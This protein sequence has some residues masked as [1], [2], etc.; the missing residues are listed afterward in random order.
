MD[1]GFRHQRKGARAKL[2]LRPSRVSIAMELPQFDRLIIIYCVLIIMLG[3]ILIRED[4]RRIW[5]LT[6]FATTLISVLGSLELLIWVFESTTLAKFR[7]TI[8][9]AALLE[10]LK[11]YLFVDLIYTAAYHP[12]QLGLIDGWIHR[13]VYI[14]IAHKLQQTYQ[15]GCVRPFWVMAI[16]T[17]IQAWAA[18]GTIPLD[19][20]NRWFGA[21]FAAFRIVW[22]AFV[23]T[24][25]VAETWVFIV[26]S[27]SIVGH[28]S[29]FAMWVGQNRVV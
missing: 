21:T 24:Q 15:I 11:A 28:A 3:R 14:L 1:G 5:I 23:L 7:S 2:D 17:A 20:A 6:A 25:M 27:L 26:I 18:I 13:T 29:W 19:T 16:P 22:P 10:F 8:V 4:H 9:S 12:R